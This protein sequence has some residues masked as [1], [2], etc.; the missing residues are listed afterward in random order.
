MT[1]VKTYFET[2]QV[3]VVKQKIAKGEICDEL[4][5]QPAPRKIGVRRPEAHSVRALGK[6]AKAK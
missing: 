1:E 2:V 6:A 5:V 4:A 3:A